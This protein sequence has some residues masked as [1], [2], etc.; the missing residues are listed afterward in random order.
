MMQSTK[1]PEAND[2]D[3][4]PLGSLIGG[5]ISWVVDEQPINPCFLN[6]LARVVKACPFGICGHQITAAFIELALRQ[7]ASCRREAEN[8]RTDFFAR[9]RQATGKTNLLT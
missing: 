6:Q 4:L 8:G 9:E 7:I 5:K 2:L 1:R 3:M